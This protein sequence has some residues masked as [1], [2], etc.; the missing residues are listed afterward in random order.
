M[1][2]TQAMI[3]RNTIDRVYL[4]RN[5]MYDI[6]QRL[7]TLR[8]VNKASDDAI[9]Y[10]RIS[11][12]EVAKS[13]NEQY[14]SNVKNAQ[15]WMDETIAALEQLHEY[16]MEAKDYALKG[17]DGTNNAET[18][19]TYAQYLRGML[20][21]AVAVGNGKFLNK[22]IFAGTNTNNATPFSQSDTSVLYTGNSED[23]NRKLSDGI[24]S[25]INISGQEIIDTNFFQSMESLILALEAND[26]VAISDTIDELTQASSEMLNLSTQVASSQNTLSLIENRLDDT[27]FKLETYLSREQDVVLEEEFVRLE[28]EEV[29]Y[30]AALQSAAKV[31][32]INILNYLG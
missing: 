30:Q 31:M 29:A 21:D 19:L 22:S 13:Q 11:R 1:R 8:K 18:R 15:N 25:A 14:M 26:D 9:A 27:K 23:I 28:S 24:V 7:S 17:A 10:S 16:S 6:N 4:N 20:E 32:R 12:F 5:N 3:T 2:V